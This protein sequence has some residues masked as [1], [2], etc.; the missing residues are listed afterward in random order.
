[1][2]LLCRAPS[3]MR[4]KFHCKGRA[5]REFRHNAYLRSRMMIDNILYDTQAEPGAADIAAVGRV[6]LGKSFENFGLKPFWNATTKIGY[7]YYYFV[8]APARG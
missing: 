2:A 6:D 1:M 3:R 4:R 5:I 8:F 7:R